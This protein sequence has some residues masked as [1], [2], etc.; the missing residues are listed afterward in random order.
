MKE[1]GNKV[2]QLKSID[3]THFH[4]VHNGTLEAPVQVQVAF[5]DGKKWKKTKNPTPILCGA[6]YT[7][8]A[9]PQ[10]HPVA[11]IE[12]EKLQV[13]S[14]LHK[15]HHSNSLNEK[16]AF[17]IHPSGLYTLQGFKK[18]QLKLVPLGHVSHW[19]AAKDPTLGIQH[20][21]KTWSITPWK[22]DTQLD[23]PEHPLVPYFWVKKTKDQHNLEWGQITC[24][25]V[26]IPI[27]SN[28]QPV[29]KEV[30]LLYPAPDTEKE[31]DKTKA[32]GEASQS[33]QPPTKKKR[34]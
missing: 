31:Q 1:Y 17:A 11:L 14:A 4:M 25:G 27:L 16:Q 12:W 10:V 32:T 6:S 28:P 3:D 21:G 15:A 5:E 33:S 34:S 26:K 19:Q 23:S 22:Q 18:N 7:R 29:E 30:Q 20:F 8:A 24:E 9:L 2:F 13:A